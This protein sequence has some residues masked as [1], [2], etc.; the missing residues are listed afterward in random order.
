[1]LCPEC[2]C[3]MRIGATRTVVEGDKSADTETRVY[4]EQDLMC[5][6]PACPN[7]AQVVQTVRTRLL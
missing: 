2:S 7:H 3:E 6:N 4:T 1:M 5:R